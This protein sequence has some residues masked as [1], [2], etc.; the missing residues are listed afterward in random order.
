M[1]NAARNAIETVATLIFSLL[2]REPA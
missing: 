1:N 2:I